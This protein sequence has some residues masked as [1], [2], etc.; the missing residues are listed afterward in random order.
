L[1]GAIFVFDLGAVMDLV[2]LQVDAVDLC[3]YLDAGD[4]AE[5]EAGPVNELCLEVCL[6]NVP[7]ESDGRR[8]VA[9]YG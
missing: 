4:P 7:A 3:I 5:A 2:L 8:I 9:I 6:A 1:V